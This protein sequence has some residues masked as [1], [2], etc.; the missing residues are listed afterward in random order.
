[1]E[2]QL[3]TPKHLQK[4]EFAELVS[5]GDPTGVGYAN[6]HPPSQWLPE[7]FFGQLAGN[8]KTYISLLSTLE[9]RKRLPQPIALYAKA[10]FDYYS[11]EPGATLLNQIY[12]R[13]VTKTTDNTYGAL[14]RADLLRK[15]ILDPGA[16]HRTKKRRSPSKTTTGEKTGRNTP[17][18]ITSHV[19]QQLEV[20]E[21]VAAEQDELQENDINITPLEHLS[22]EEWN[23]DGSCVMCLCMDYQLAA[24]AALRSGTLLKANTADYAILAGVFVPF[25]ATALMK[26]VFSSSTLKAIRKN[27][28]ISAPDVDIDDSVVQ[29]AIRLHANGQHDDAAVHLQNLK[30]MRMLQ[31]FGTAL[32]NLPLRPIEVSEETLIT[33]Y[34]SPLLRTFTH[35]PSEE[36][37]AHFPNT[38]STT[39]VTLNIK[40]DRPDFKVAWEDTEIAFGEVTGMAQKS[41]KRKNGWDLWRLLRFGKAALEAGAASVPLVQVVYDLGTIWNMCTPVRGLYIAIEIGPFMMPTHLYA[42]GGLQ[43]SLAPLLWLQVSS[44]RL[45]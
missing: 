24:T 40:P 5:L 26:N 41:D 19:D 20:E 45:D 34:V 30:N 16:E 17:H 44:I 37:I 43:A 33:N 10:L 15:H 9:K 35:Y 22:C 36:I 21:D 29:T 7:F 2:D 3:A 28:S 13:S 12:Q 4:P 6:T 39:Q 14:K 11:S 32:S 8:A 38:A 18:A 31:L 42:V 1:M 25:S 23:V 27:V